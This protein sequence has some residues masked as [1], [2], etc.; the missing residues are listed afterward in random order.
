MV[1]N[2]SPSTICSEIELSNDISVEVLRLVHVLHPFAGEEP[3]V[4]LVL[5]V[6]L[7]PRPRRSGKQVHELLRRMPSRAKVWHSVLEAITRRWWVQGSG[8]VQE[9]ELLLSSKEHG[10]TKL[11]TLLLARKQERKG[12]W[13]LSVDSRC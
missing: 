8:S 12:L 2:N 3:G 9:G 13:Q 7:V 4:Q 11:Y 10:Y 1:K 6:I 5:R